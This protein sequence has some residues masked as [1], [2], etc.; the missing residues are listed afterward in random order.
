LNTFTDEQKVQLIRSF[1]WHGNNVTHL[2]LYLTYSFMVF[3]FLASVFFCQN[4]FAGANSAP[5]FELSSKSRIH[6]TYTIQIFSDGKLH[7]HG[8]FTEIKG[9]RYAQITP[10]Q[11]DELVMT[12]LSMPF[13]VLK[14]GEY[15]RKKDNFGAS[16]KTI[17]YKDE[18]IAINIEDGIIFTVLEKKSIS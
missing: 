1:D 16:R 17:T 5:V 12:F 2:P 18:Y 8:Y 6:L 14:Q 15:E 7:F 4:S 13:E 3:I 9:E 11:L 10:A